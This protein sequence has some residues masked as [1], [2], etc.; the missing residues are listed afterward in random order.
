MEML[1]LNRLVVLILT[2]SGSEFEGTTS[3]L[4]KVIFRCL[5]LYYFALNKRE[6]VVAAKLEQLIK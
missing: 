3:V 2:K 5:L 4:V 6:L 1:R